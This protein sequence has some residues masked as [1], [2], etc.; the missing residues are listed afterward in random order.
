MSKKK[1]NRYV[2]SYD[3]GTGQ[4]IVVY[5]K[6]LNEAEAKFEAGDV[7]E[8]DPPQV[9][10]TIVCDQYHVADSLRNLA[11]AVENEDIDVTDYEYEDAR[12]CA[13]FSEE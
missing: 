8:E 2:M 1:L 9:K 10:I 6:D 7:V 3:Q 12:C 13:T 4:D 11:S 5:A